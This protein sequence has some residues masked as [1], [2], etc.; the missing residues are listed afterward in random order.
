MAKVIVTLGK[1]KY[2][3]GFTRESALAAE[4]AGM[5]TVNPQEKGIL[6]FLDKLFFFAFKTYQPNMTED[7]VRDIVAKIP[8]KDELGKALGEIYNSTLSYL[9]EPDADSEGNAMWK[10]SQ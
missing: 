4:E 5:N 8:Q 7:E 6:N 10:V 1:K 9:S 3:L 2:E